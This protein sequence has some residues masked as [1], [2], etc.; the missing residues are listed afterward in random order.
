MKENSITIKHS[1]FISKP[2][3]LVW[4]YTQNYDHRTKWDDAVLEATVLQEAPN[5]IVKLRTKGNTTMTFVYKQDERPYKTSLVVKEISSPLIESAGGSWIYE[6]QNGKTLWQQTN[7]IIFKRTFA[8]K[9]TLPI[10]KMLFSMQTKKAMKK[11]KRE[12]EKI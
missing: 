4:D 9:L 3:E 10:L 5:R 2:R 12:I 1:V 8:V 6:E 11:A 7:S